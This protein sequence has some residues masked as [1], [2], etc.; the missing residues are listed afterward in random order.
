MPN[1]QSEAE[2]A[3]KEIQKLIS[4][5]YANVRKA[6]E[7]AKQHKLCFSFDVAYGMGGT[8]VG[9]PDENYDNPGETG[10]LASSHS[11]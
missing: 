8:F 3:Q 6:E 10:W 2:K 7:L 5:A 9:D 4:E 11:C 1:Y